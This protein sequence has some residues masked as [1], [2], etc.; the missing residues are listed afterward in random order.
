VLRLRGLDVTRSSSGS[1]GSVGSARGR[2]V[3]EELLGLR[4]SRAGLIV[5]VVGSRSGVGRFRGRGR[6][7]V[8]QG[9]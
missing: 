2:V 7:F 1:G 6:Y 5:V 3:S 4:D 9:G 8:G